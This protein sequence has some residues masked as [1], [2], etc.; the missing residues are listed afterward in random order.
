MFNDISLDRLA[1][2]HTQDIEHSE[3]CLCF[4]PLYA[5]S[6][7]YF[8]TFYDPNARRNT[9]HFRQLLSSY[10][11]PEWKR[12]AIP[13]DTSTKGK[14]RASTVPEL[15][16]VI[17][18]RKATKTGE[19]VYRAILDVPAADTSLS[20]DWWKAVLDTP[21]LR[22]EWDPAVESTQTIEMLDPTTRV[23]KVNFTLGWPA[24]IR[25]VCPVYWGAIVV[26]QARPEATYYVF[27]AT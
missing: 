21:E 26:T 4:W 14:A 8:T 12:I 10:S 24:N 5:L 22:K 18:H 20:L 17:L 2:R 6:L 16:D 19:S 9:S 1:A 7:P 15:V 13:S 27:L 23:S 25:M 11:S 3:E